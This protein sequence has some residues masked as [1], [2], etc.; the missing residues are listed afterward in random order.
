MSSRSGDVRESY[1]CGKCDE[2]GFTNEIG[3][4]RHRKQR[5]PYQPI[6]LF[7]RD[8]HL[9]TCE[10][11]GIMISKKKRNKHA[12]KCTS[13]YNGLNHGAVNGNFENI[14]TRQLNS[15]ML[16][17][18]VC[19]IGPKIV[20]AVIFT[21]E[22]IMYILLMFPLLFFSMMLLFERGEYYGSF[23]SLC[24]ILF[25]CIKWKTW[26]PLLTYF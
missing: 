11:C 23:F 6:H 19:H 15:K 7:Y 14:H 18:V 24:F 4:E 12:T 9:E 10:Y 22:A 17:D 13:R 25:L 3:M 21:R 5:H 2:G 26:F 16:E 20:D 8:H 1:K